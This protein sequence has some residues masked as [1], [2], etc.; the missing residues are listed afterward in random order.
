MAVNTPLPVVPVPDGIRQTTCAVYPADL[1][2]SAADE[3]EALSAGEIP[4]PAWPEGDPLLSPPPFDAKRLM[5][6]Y[7]ATKPF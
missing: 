6:D 4:R 7:P 3:L 2:T 5:R 1:A